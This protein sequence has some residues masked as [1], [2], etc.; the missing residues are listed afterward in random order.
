MERVEKHLLCHCVD[1]LTEVQ[2]AVKQTP[3]QRLIERSRSGKPDSLYLDV[4]PENTLQLKLIQDYDRHIVLVTEERGKF[5]YEVIDEAEVVIFSDPTDR[6]KQ[7]SQFIQMGI[8]KEYIGP[9]SL[10]ADLLAN[11][12]KSAIWEAVGGLPVQLSGPCCS[13]TVVKRG[14]ILFTLILNY[15]SEDITIACK[16]FIAT[17]MLDDTEWAEG[18]YRFS[19]WRDI[20]FKGPTNEKTYLTYLGKRYAEY[21]EK[22]GLF[23]HTFTAIEK[24]PGGP[25]RILY[26]SD[27]NPVTPGFIFSNGEKIGEWLGWMAFCRYSPDLV[28]YSVYPETFFA[29][30]DILMTPSPPYSILEASENALRLN[31]EKMKY[32]ENPSRYR[33]MILVTHRKNHLIRAKI[34]AEKSRI[35]FSE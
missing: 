15:V 26:L 5:N 31:Y 21:L 13:L 3:A 17:R 6:S 24:E 22:A 10:F 23:D 4:L 28:A 1:A 12:W 27:L 34:E 7:F 19:E 18:S 9:D 33:E 25:A 2:R 29:K 11:P 16:D 14:E 35:L 32:F 20:R 30:D 8:D